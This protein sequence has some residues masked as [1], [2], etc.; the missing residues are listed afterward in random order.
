VKCEQVVSK[1]E[2]VIHEWLAVP[3]GYEGVY[4]ILATGRCKKKCVFECGWK[5]KHI[6]I[7]LVKNG[8]SG[9]E[10]RNLIQTI[11]WLLYR[12]YIK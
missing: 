3:A 11:N 9:N 4:K 6:C 5:G 1:P 12:E 7:T 8:D 2:Y 10:E